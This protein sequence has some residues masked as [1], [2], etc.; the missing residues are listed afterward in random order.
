MIV[1]HAPRQ[2]LQQQRR[3]QQEAHWRHDDAVPQCVHVPIAT[4]D[5]VDADV[6][7]DDGQADVE[8]AYEDSMVA[9]VAVV[10]AKMGESIIKD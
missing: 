7:V 9:V 6:D 10:F 4:D 2:Q 1:H 5:D 3:Q 8:D